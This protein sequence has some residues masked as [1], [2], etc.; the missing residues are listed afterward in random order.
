MKR[1]AASL[2]ALSALTHQNI[3]GLRNWQG[4]VASLRLGT[5]HMLMSLPVA[6]R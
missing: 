2:T 1:T 6:S 4:A 5:M 3:E